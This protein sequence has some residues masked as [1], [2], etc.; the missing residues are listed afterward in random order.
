MAT[1]APATC[2]HC[3]QVFMVK[4]PSGGGTHTAAHNPGCGRLNSVSYSNGSVIKTS[5]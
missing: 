3:G 4:L 5:R 2:A 1:T